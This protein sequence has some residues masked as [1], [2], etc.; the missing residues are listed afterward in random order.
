MGL[1]LLPAMAA[2]LSRLA[3]QLLQNG[4]SVLGL[5]HKELSTRLMTTLSPA[6]AADTVPLPPET[7]RAMQ[8]SMDRLLERDWQEMEAGLYPE[9][10][11]FDAPWLT[12]LRRYPLIWLDTPTIWE[13]R[14]RRA[15]RD[16][17]SHARR[18]R[19]PAYYLQNFHHQT[20]GYLSEHS[21][22]L[23]ELQVELLFNGTA[24]AMRRRVI[25]PLRQGLEAFADRPAAACRV[26]DVATGTG[27]TLRQLMAAFPDRQMLG[28]DLSGA[29][30]REANRALATGGGRLPQLIEA[31]AEAM[32]YADGSMQAV[33]CVFLLHELPGPV[34]QRVLQE[35]FRVLEPGGTLVLAD[36]IQRAD[37]PA[38]TVPMENFPRAFH[39]PYYIDYIADDIDGRLR[40]AGFE[41][42]RGASHFMTRVWSATRPLAG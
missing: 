9:S 22:S 39:E 3:Y 7:F 24:D 29:Y 12:W 13:R 30:L 18:D 10:L 34:R 38:F 16:L 40:A 23:Y 33:S 4:K 17:P 21:A 15:T 2:T 14:R 5:T 19:Y 35:C 42:I 11:L 20:D 28:L 26:L 1:H 31:N 37:S 32:P 36:S 25:A 6:G 8:R 41:A 27:S